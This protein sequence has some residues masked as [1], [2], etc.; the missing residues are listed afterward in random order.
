MQRA[1]RAPRLNAAGK[2]TFLE[3]R[4]PHWRTAH[5]LVRMNT[6]ADAVN[7]KTTQA[8]TQLAKCAGGKVV[9]CVSCRVR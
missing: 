9:E 1:P 5:A 4:L 3:A 6:L 2:T 8:K 7:R